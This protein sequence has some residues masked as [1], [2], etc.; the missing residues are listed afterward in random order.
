MK[1]IVFSIFFALYAAFSPAVA[2]AANE[3]PFSKVCNGTSVIGDGGQAQDSLAGNSFVCNETPKDPSAPDG[4]IVKVTNL[5]ALIGGIAAVII[6]M[7]GGF[8]YIMASGDSGKINKAKDMIIFAL[9]GLA[10]IIFART[11][12]VFVMSKL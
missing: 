6:I 7:V 12:I 2:I 11:I 3:D 1:K 10:V 5:I 9:V 8:S 4:I